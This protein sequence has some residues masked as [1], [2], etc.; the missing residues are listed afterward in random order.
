MFH[1]ATRILVRMANRLGAITA[2][3]IIVA[4]VGAASAADALPVMPDLPN[5]PT[6]TPPTIGT[7]GDLNAQ[8]QGWSSTFASRAASYITA[9][10]ANLGIQ[11]AEKGF[12][13]AWAQAQAEAAS[14]MGSLPD[15]PQ[16]PSMQSLQ[17][18]LPPLNAKTLPPLPNLAAA[19]VPLAGGGTSD[20]TAQPTV[21][22]GQGLGSD[23]VPVEVNPSYL[24]NPATSLL[25]SCDLGGSGCLFSANIQDLLGQSLAAVGTNASDVNK[26]LAE[27]KL[28]TIQGEASA[29]LNSTAAK[30]SL[31]AILSAP[32][33]SSPPSDFAILGQTPVG[34][35]IKSPVAQ[36]AETS[37]KAGANSYLHG[38]GITGFVA[39]TAVSGAGALGRFITGL[40]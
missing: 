37:I 19:S 12:A 32:L 9:A 3:T 14:I 13:S 7:P 38:G 28:S 8:I 4:C 34:Q 15:A 36:Q 33:P 20:L 1:K 27:T 6:V 29:Q 30:Q 17:G 10:S 40:F 39:N 23:I 11:H 26:F 21:G 16:L 25:K 24:S 22:G 35:L 2:G 18:L 31:S 5:P